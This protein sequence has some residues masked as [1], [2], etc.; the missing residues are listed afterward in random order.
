MG[1]N[2]LCKT[3]CCQR[4]TEKSLEKLQ[5]TD[6]KWLLNETQKYQKTAEEKVLRNKLE[7][8]L[9]NMMS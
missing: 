4:Q 1:N 8:L 3:K 5:I 9:E 6:V 7:V 2:I